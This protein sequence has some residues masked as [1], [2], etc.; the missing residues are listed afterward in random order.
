MS[1]VKA[2][3][4]KVCIKAGK[5]EAAVRVAL[6]ANIESGGMIY[7]PNA[8]AMLQGHGISPHEV[9]G[10]LSAMAE[11]GVYKPTDDPYWGQWI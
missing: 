1:N 7:L 6:M 8:Q 3:C 10:Y 2:H 9:A 11:K 4:I 5:I